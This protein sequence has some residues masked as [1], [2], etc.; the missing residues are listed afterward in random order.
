[1]ATV[2]L[3]PHLKRHLEADSTQVPGG[4]VRSVLDAVFARNKQLRSYILDDEG[5]LRQHVAIF[6][7]DRRVTDR[8]ALSDPVGDQSEV[9]VLQALSGG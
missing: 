8:R 9:Y 1:M 6:V 7:D 4:T 3:T 2:R 5:A